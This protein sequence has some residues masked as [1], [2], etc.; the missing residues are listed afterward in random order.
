MAV[1]VVGGVVAGGVVGVVVGSVVVLGVAVEVVEVV[2]VVTAFVGVVGMELGGIAGSALVCGA[3][4]AVVAG[5]P[6]MADEPACAAPAG[7]VTGV[8][9]LGPAGVALGLAPFAALGR[10]AHAPIDNAVSVK[11]QSMTPLGAGGRPNQSAR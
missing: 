4:E 3:C 9:V 7:G 8:A 6:D 11:Q 10:S 1:V 2:G 5:A